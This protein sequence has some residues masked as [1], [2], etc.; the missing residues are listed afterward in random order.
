M[1][2][3]LLVLVL[4]VGLVAGGRYALQE[5]YIGAPNYDD[6]FTGGAGEPVSTELFKATF[7][8]QPQREVVTVDAGDGLEFEMAVHETS[9]RTHTFA[10]GAASLPPGFVP[11]GAAIDEALEAGARATADVDDGQVLTWVHKQHLGRE[12][13]EFTVRIDS[14]YFKATALLDHERLYVL[15]VGDNRNPP[16]AYERFVHSVEIP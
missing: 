4:C 1:K 16:R 6:Y 2:K 15:M 9:N 8:A 5:G 3:A 10:V 11:E 13:L 12:A 14:S 7:P